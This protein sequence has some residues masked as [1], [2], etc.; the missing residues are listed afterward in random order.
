MVLV[1]SAGAAIA[2]GVSAVLGSSGSSSDGAGQPG[3]AAGAAVPTV[4]PPTAAPASVP[5]AAA[6]SSVPTFKVPQGYSLL[7]HDEFEGS[8]LDTSK[9]AVDTGNAREG[10]QVG[11]RLAV[12][13]W[14]ASR[15]GGRWMA[16][17]G[18]CLLPPQ[19]CIPTALTYRLQTYSSHPDN[20]RVADGKLLITSLRM[21]DQYTSGRIDSRPGG[22]WYPG[23]MVGWCG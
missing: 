10:V 19:H 20:V 21:G 23:M 4:A 1:V 14:C 2:V 11:G 13:W 17:W 12:A 6:N 3:T 16:A 8:Q 15:S 18:I 22:A 5:V 7:F 9:W